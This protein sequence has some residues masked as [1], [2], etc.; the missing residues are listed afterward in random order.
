MSRDAAHRFTGYRRRD[1]SV[2]VRNHVLVLSPT[3]L[4]SAAAQRIANLVLGTV[5]V[6][7]GFGRGQV[8]DD[9]RLHFDTLAGLARN[10][11]VAAVLVVSAADAITEAYVDALRE[12]GKPVDGLSLRGWCARRRRRVAN[13]R[14][15][16]ISFSPSS[17]GIPTRRPDSCAI[18]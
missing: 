15:S 7:S 12:S 1:G 3:G 6:T 9:A 18:R 11:N 17:A 10:P 13:R 16:P 4:T 8:G 5:A 14:R 2:G